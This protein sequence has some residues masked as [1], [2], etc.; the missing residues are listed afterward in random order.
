MPVSVLNMPKVS[1]AMKKYFFY[2]EAVLSR[3]P[4]ATKYAMNEAGKQIRISAINAINRRGG[5]KNNLNVVDEDG[6]QIFVRG[7]NG[8]K[9]KLKQ[10]EASKPG[11]APMSQIGTLRKFTSYAFDTG[12]QSEVVGSELEGSKSGAPEVLEY[13][14]TVEMLKRYQEVDSKTIMRLK[15]P[16]R[17]RVRIA[18][19]PY[20]GPALDKNMSA[21]AEVWRNQL[22]N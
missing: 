4:K 8:Q 17:E 20:M 15:K 11:E 13:G 3:L 2:R 14:G 10:R 5:K 21:V 22:S 6:N 9:L 19:R 12:S 7:K 1:V 18:A 16:Q